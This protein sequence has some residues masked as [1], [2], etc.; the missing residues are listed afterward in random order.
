[1]RNISA[2]YIGVNTG[3]IMIA[4][5][6]IMFYILKL[7]ETGTAQYII[8]GI[9][10]TGIILSLILFKINSPNEHSFKT[11]F[12]QGFKTFIVA[13]LLIVVYIYFF[14]KNNP[15]ILEKAITE[16]NA[17]ILKEGNRTAPE[18]DANAEK[19]RGIFIPGMLMMNTI[20]YL[21]LGSLVSMIA[22]GLLSQNNMQDNKNKR[23][24]PV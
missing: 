5:A 24:S 21:V 2:K 7:P 17:L 1:M 15:Q 4:S 6:L 10:I 8:W 19:F 12:T 18:I 9:Y 20:I 11:F 23:N 16:N 22:G 3:I 14:Y 13:A